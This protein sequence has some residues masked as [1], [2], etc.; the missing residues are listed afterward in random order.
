MP[1]ILPA[2]IRRARLEERALEAKKYSRKGGRT[3]LV[4][5]R[6]VDFGIGRMLEVIA[7]MEDYDYMIRS[8][9]NAKDADKWLG[10]R[11]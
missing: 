4:F 6:K 3:A 7:E 10:I 11:N 2:E 5:S 8:F 9:R 1:S